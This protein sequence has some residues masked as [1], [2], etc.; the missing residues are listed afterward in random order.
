[1]QV[2]PIMMNRSLSFKEA[3]RLDMT[4]K[5]VDIQ[6]CMVTRWAAVRPRK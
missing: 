4:P 5:R 6:T 3:G 1:M 2:R